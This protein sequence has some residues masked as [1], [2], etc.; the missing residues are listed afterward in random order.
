ME[1]SELTTWGAQGGWRKY[2]NEGKRVDGIL[3][4]VDE[5]HEQKIEWKMKETG[6]GH[7]NAEDLEE[8]LT[9]AFDL[10]LEG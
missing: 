1:E 3:N 8:G 9:L 5:R 4:Q 10:G 7:W 6:R 2:G